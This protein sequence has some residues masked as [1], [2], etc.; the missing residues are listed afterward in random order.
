MVS[1]T[2]IVFYYL[3][4]FRRIIWFPT[5]DSTIIS[6]FYNIYP[7]K[8]LFSNSKGQEMRL[9]LIVRAG[10]K[11]KMMGQWRHDYSMAFRVE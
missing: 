6:L 8:R 9:D 5:N 1:D 10:S 2:E 3:Y 11:F 4:G 7:K